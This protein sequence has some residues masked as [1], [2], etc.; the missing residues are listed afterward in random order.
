VNQNRIKTFGGGDIV[1]WSEGDIDAGKGAKTALIAPQPE[2]SYDPSTGTFTTKL[3]G[4]AAGSGIGTVKTR[5]DVPAGDVILIAPQ[6]VVNAGDAGIQSSGN[7][8]IAAQSVRNADNIQATGSQIGVPTHSTVDIGALTNASNATAATQQTDTKSQSNTNDRPSIIIVE[9][10][11]YGGGDGSP[12]QDL[13]E[14][15]DR[16]I[17]DEQSY[18]PNS[19]VHM[20]GNGKLTE[21]QKKNLTDEEKNKLDRLANQSGPL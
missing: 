8:V 3:S 20:L 16:K 9:V 11:G 17:K 1:I 10:L 5:P 7:V 21:E 14:K 4:D 13:R 15:N 12:Q 18:D 6:G 19:A 2:V